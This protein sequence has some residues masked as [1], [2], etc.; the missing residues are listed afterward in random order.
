MSVSVILLFVHCKPH[1]HGIQTVRRYIHTH[2]P[3]TVRFIWTLF[4]VILTLY[5]LFTS[6]WKG[7]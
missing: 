6:P 3:H 4:D 5:M 1:I 7:V 2:I